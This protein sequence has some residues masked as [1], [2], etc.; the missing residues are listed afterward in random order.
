MGMWVCGYSKCNSGI[1]KWWTKK[2]EAAKE[3]AALSLDI[4][5]SLLA[6]GCR[7]GSISIDSVDPLDSFEKLLSLF[8]GES[9]P[10]GL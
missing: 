7:K 2:A 3:E 10:L 6:V 8:H 1:N 9:T 5:N 4:E